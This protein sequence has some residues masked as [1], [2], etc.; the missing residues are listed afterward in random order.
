MFNHAR[1]KLHHLDHTLTITRLRLA[2]KT[3]NAWLV[4][5]IVKHHGDNTTIMNYAPPSHKHK[6]KHGESLLKLAARVAGPRVMAELLK[7]PCIN[8]NAVDFDDKQNTPLH[9][10]VES[11]KLEV[12]EQLCAHEKIDPNIL[13]GE[14]KTALML[15]VSHADKFPATAAFIKINSLDVNVHDNEGRTA[16]HFVCKRPAP[17]N[18]ARGLLDTLLKS[19]DPAVNCQDNSGWTPL[20][21]ASRA[22]HGSYVIRLLREG[23]D[24]SLKNDIGV[25]ADYIANVNGQ[26]WTHQLLEEIQKPQQEAE[27]ANK[28][29]MII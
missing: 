21:Y 15:V 7:S 1:K 6:G 26:P 19:K 10:A 22:G 24:K 29:L 2:I 9:A 12:I 25:T 17:L 20:M 27:T 28:K 8:P 5:R 16:L 4:A 13:N 18:E 3:D 11:G 23:A 14:H